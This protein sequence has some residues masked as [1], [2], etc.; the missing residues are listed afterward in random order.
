MSSAVNY[1]PM[2]KK[3][4]LRSGQNYNNVLHLQKGPETN[5]PLTVYGYAFKINLNSGCAEKLK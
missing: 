3:N 1:V 5:F 4:G 2:H